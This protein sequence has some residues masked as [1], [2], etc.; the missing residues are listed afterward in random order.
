MITNDSFPEDEYIERRSMFKLPCLIAAIGFSLFILVL[1]H[2]PQK[3]IPEELQLFSFDKILHMLAYGII[4]GLALLSIKKPFALRIY[5][6]V[7]LVVSILGGFD[8][9][10]QSFVGRACSV[11]DWLADLG[12]IMAALLIF[13]AIK[14]YPMGI[15]MPGRA[16][17]KSLSDLGLKK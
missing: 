7:I 14:V 12:G 16:C 11:Y 1:S 6:L 17:S 15:I 4:T 9:Y 8:E 13:G 10:T 2:I 5:L 3:H